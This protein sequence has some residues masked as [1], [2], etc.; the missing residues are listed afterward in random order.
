MLGKQREIVATTVWPA[1]WVEL[2]LLRYSLPRVFVGR[3][4]NEI[5][6]NLHQQ[7]MAIC[8]LVF[9]PVIMVFVPVNTGC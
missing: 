9:V 3:F 4:I 6:Q 1:D 2:G 7:F 5:S 8:N